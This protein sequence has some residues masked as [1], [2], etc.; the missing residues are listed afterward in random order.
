MAKEPDLEEGRDFRFPQAVN[1]SCEYIA[2]RAHEVASFFSYKYDG[3][4]ESLVEAIG[5]SVRSVD[6]WDMREPKYEAIHILRNGQFTIYLSK[7]TSRYVKNFSI[8]HELGHF[9]LHF[10]NG[11]VKDFWRFESQNP[12]PMVAYRNGDQE[13]EQQANN[14]AVALLIPNEVLS[15][16]YSTLNGNVESISA[17]FGVEQYIVQRRLSALHLGWTN[18]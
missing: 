13:V 4:M 3:K 12:L 16:R 6:Y 17:S 9:F 5:G 11:E 7:R 2:N 14:F 1:V 10:M 18:I 8:A 15:D